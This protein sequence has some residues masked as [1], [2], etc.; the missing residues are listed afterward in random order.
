M[1]TQRIRLGIIGTGIAARELHWPPLQRLRDHFEIVALCN[2]TRAKADDF[3]ELVGGRP[4]ITTDYHELLSWEEVDAVDILLPIALNAP[5]AVDALHA[6]KHVVVEKPI[7]GEA[8]AGRALLAE[9]DRH[10]DLVLLVAENVRYE[11]RFREA[12]RLID[13]G[14]IGRP[15]MLHADILAPLNPE[16]PYL[17]TSWRETPQHLGGYLSDGGVHHAAGLQVLGGPVRAVQGLVT[18]FDSERDPTDTLLANLLFESGAVGHLTYSVGVPQ[19][20]MRPFGVYGTGGSLFVYPDRVVLRIGRE[21]DVIPVA[22]HPNG[23]DLELIDFHRSIV[24]GTPPQSGARQGLDDL[25]VIDAVFRSW[26]E[27]RLITVR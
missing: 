13:E 24:D 2:R 9:V 10:P 6:G 17:A 20:E 22:P 21:E 7:A 26:Q 1:Q 11:P 5:V 14:R 8:S 27:E 19:G 3:A 15:V 25:L 18:S 16:S 4:R 12:R 23:F